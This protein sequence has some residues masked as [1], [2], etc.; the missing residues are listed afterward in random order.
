MINLITFLHI[1]LSPMQITLINI[2][3]SIIIA[4]LIL[5][6]SLALFLRRNK[7]VKNQVIKNEATNAMQ[8]NV[9]EHQSI[10][11][12]SLANARFLASKGDYRKAIID[13]YLALRKE[14][15]IIFMVT[16]MAYMTEYEI[17]KSILEKIKIS[18]FRNVDENFIKILMNLYK[19]YEKSRFSSD[20]I[21]IDD[22]NVFINSIELIRKS[23]K[24]G[25]RS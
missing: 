20:N 19:L 18:Y 21:T 8:Q 3:S 6:I 10:L 24:R 15:S 4:L 7:K 17:M 23:I 16:P 5:V 11:L 22:Y 9:S 12:S 13:G 14:L 1:V 2:I 25:E